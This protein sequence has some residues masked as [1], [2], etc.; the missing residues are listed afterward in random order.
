MED[1]ITNMWQ[2]CRFRS[3][4]VQPRSG[5]ELIAST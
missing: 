4:A 2:S 5:R 1:F 3:G